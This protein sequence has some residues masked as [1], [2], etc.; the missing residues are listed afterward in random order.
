[1]VVMGR[2]RF[3]GAF[4]RDE[5]KDFK[6]A[7]AALDKVGIASLSERAFNTLSGGERQLVMIAQALA[8]ESRA[9]VL[10]EPT[11]ALDLVHQHDLVELMRRLSHD[12]GLTVVFASHNPSH[13]LHI[14]D[15]CLMMDRDGSYEFGPARSVIA[16]DSLRRVFGVEAR[17]I[18][19]DDNG[20][21]VSYGVLPIL[22]PF[23]RMETLMKGD[24]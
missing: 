21:G 4:S 7:R 2:A 23:V 17:I 13:A 8:T 11:S 3:Q 15:R 16:E 12:E 24:R 19:L 22:K 10:D 6:I 5:Q 18:R 14:A 1:M 9:L 20:R